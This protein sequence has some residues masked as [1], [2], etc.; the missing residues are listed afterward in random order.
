MT[1]LLNLNIGKQQIKFDQHKDCCCID[2]AI[3]SGESESFKFKVDS[4]RIKNREWE[5]EME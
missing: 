5:V 3:Y 1:L 4:E 2:N